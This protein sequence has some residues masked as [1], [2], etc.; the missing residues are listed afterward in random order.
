MWCEQRVYLY[1]ASEHPIGYLTADTA[2]CTI[3]ASEHRES[4]S[5]S[6]SG[7]DQ[8]LGHPNL[9]ITF[10]ALE[11]LQDTG[12]IPIEI[13]SMPMSRRFVSLIALAVV[14]SGCYLKAQSTKT[15]TAGE[16]GQHVGE[17]ATVCGLVASARYAARSRGGPTF[18]NF[19]KPYP[20]QIF[21]I[22][23]WREDRTKFGAPDVRY[24]AKRICVTGTIA[25]YRGTPEIVA[26]EP[27]QIRTQ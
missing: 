22:V 9:K 21:T 24:S 14:I 1:T 19:D 4:P 27:S 23:I 20:D 2:R 15:L 11:L 25:S 26:R 5:L 17:N 10:C 3:F 13:E 12:E 8:G 16:A 6:P 18:L 7:A